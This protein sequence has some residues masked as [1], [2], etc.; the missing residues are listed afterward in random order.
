MIFSPVLGKGNKS[1]MHLRYLPTANTAKCNTK[2]TTGG[3]FYYLSR[4]GIGG[5]KK[6]KMALKTMQLKPSHLNSFC[7]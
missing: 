7:L 6:V 5:T 1:L 3:I 4:A 2:L